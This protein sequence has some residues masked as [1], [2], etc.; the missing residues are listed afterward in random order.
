MIAAAPPSWAGRPF[1][2]M[3]V[4]G[5]HL[6]MDDPAAD[7]DAAL[8]AL[9][10]EVDNLNTALESSRTI[11]QA[12]GILMERHGIS[13]D[14]AFGRLVTMS[15][16][17]NIKLRDVAENMVALRADAPTIDSDDAAALARLEDGEP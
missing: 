8:V 15:Q 7:L 12:T 10:A 17:S 4:R 1:P 6:V 2:P 14:E 5:K 9:R 13:P 11:G 3:G 16:D